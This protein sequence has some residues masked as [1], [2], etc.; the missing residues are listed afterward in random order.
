MLRW[1]DEQGLDAVPLTRYFTEIF[2][3]STIPILLILSVLLCLVLSAGHV[4][5]RSREV[6]VHRLLGLS[7]AETTSIEIKR[8]SITLV[9][10]YLVAPLLVAGLLYAY[11]GW[12]E[13]WV[14]WRIYFTISLIL[15]ACLLIGYLGGQFLVRRTSIPQSVKGKIHARPILYSDRRPRRVPG[16]CAQCGCNPGRVF[17]GA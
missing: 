12:A 9:L 15:S 6:G 17:S 16:C 7:V 14:F 3:S 1:L 10:A 2:A 5:A 4:L 8:Q 13:G 11:N